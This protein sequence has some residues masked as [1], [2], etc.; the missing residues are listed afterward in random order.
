MLL[1]PTEAW[2]LLH[3]ALG[4]E[5]QLRC[6]SCAYSTF[7]HL[8]LL[9]TAMSQPTQCSVSTCHASIRLSAASM[10]CMLPHSKISVI[11]MCCV[12]ICMTYI[13]TVCVVAT[14]HHA[15][16]LRASGHLVATNC[17]AVTCPADSCQRRLSHQWSVQLT[18][19]R[20]RKC[21]LYAS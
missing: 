8:L 17:S 14:Q 4:R 18:C 19:L 7:C 16:S 13:A 10:I 1:L 20:V 21:R 12:D 11:Y 9:A 3:Q 2:Q 15:S 5:K 6:T